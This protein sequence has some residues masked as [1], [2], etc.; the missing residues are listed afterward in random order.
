MLHAGGAKIGLATHNRPLRVEDED[1]VSA[2][3]RLHP[4]LSLIVNFPP[5]QCDSALHLVQACR[6]NSDIKIM[7]ALIFGLHYT[8]Y[9]RGKH[10]QPLWGTFVDERLDFAD[11]TIDKNLSCDE[12]PR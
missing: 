1:N 9:L 8:A 10:L 12:N 6:A 3:S 11:T 4:D 5:P 7:V 2:S